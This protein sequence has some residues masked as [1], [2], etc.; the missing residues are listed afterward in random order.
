MGDAP[1]LRAIEST[2]TRQDLAQFLNEK[3]L[4]NPE[5]IRLQ[6]EIATA[7]AELARARMAELGIA[8]DGLM[9]SRVRED[10]SALIHDLAPGG[11]VEAS[12]VA[13]AVK[14]WDVREIVGDLGEA[15]GR[16]QLHADAASAPGRSVLSNIEI[17]TRVR[18][19]RTI[20]EW[21]QAQRA[22]GQPDN[23]KGLYEA[24]GKLWRSITELDNLVVERTVRGALRP[25]LMEQVKTGV[26]DR[27]VDAAKQ[28]TK[29]LDAL[30]AVAAGSPDIAV[31]DR[32][33]KNTLGAQRGGELD[34]SHL[35]D[36]TLKTRGLP[37]KNLDPR[38]GDHFDAALDL[39]STN[40][41]AKEARS[42]LEDLAR[43][44]LGAK[45]AELLKLAPGAGK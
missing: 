30:Q 25:V 42:L 19:F 16:A 6:T 15:I 36:L 14:R 38:L 40:M 20:K 17:V 26:D 12:R 5:R 7:R 39:G 32:V 4:S 11:S 27:P 3:L 9:Q 37:G 21:Q 34:L 2:V 1:A 41:S 43:E 22:Q 10:A 33:G 18:G 23:P 35:D 45:V 8:G 28:N 13:D 44:I 29:A 31:Y 24:D